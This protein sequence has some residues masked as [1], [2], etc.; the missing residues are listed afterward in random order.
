MVS[1]AK[2]VRLAAVA[3]T[4]GLL[5]VIPAASAASSVSIGSPLQL[6]S[7]LYVNVPVTYSCTAFPPGPYAYSSMSISLEQTNNKALAQSSGFTPPLC[8]GATHTDLVAIYPSISGYT[9]TGVPFKPGA[10]IASA[11]VYDCATDPNT[12]I[13]TCDNTSTGPVAVKISSGNS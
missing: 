2:R 11:S 12:W 7:K 4:L 1:M 10:A 6:V 9:S 13:Q 5:V 8:D 3:S